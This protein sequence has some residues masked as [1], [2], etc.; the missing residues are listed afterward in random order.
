MIANRNDYF[1][2]GSTAADLVKNALVGWYTDH[3]ASAYAPFL[4]CFSTRL[5]PWE[6]L[7]QVYERLP[8]ELEGD[9]Q[10][11]AKSGMIIGVS[12][13]LAD[14]ELARK[15]PDAFGQLIEFGGAVGSI[16]VVEALQRVI[17]H[18]NLKG[19]QE[20][21]NLASRAFAVAQRVYPVLGRSFLDQAERNIGHYGISVVD[22][23]LVWAREDSE[24]WASH[25][26]R[27]ET[28]LHDYYSPRVGSP[29]GELTLFDVSK[30]Y[31]DALGPEAFRV[32]LSELF[33]SPARGRLSWLF[34]AI[35]NPHL[36]PVN[37]GKLQAMPR[38]RML[39]DPGNLTLSQYAPSATS[40]LEVSV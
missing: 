1:K 36:E 14:Q 11:S 16:H 17:G 35:E 21:T 24:N 4:D 23:L 28:E 9:Y 31:R 13:L 8:V 29:I 40:M 3:K 20:T 12:R 6:I 22:I 18:P 39:V 5:E 38:H 7:Y 30:D 25:I 27:L 2:E 32:Q 37:P 33:L 15:F 34:A 26:L 10:A 19:A